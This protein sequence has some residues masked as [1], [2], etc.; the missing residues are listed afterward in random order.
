MFNY[1]YCKIHNTQFHP[2]RSRSL[3]DV[4]Y[5][6]TWKEYV[7]SYSWLTNVTLKHRHIEAHN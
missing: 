4:T 2:D 1:S 7:A 3:G 6:R 5:L